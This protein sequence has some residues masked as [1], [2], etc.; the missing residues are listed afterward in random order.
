MQI[1]GTMRNGPGALQAVH[2][3]WDEVGT[4]QEAPKQAR[5]VGGG[6]QMGD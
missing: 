4:M 5:A 6:W 2:Q 1:L 3:A